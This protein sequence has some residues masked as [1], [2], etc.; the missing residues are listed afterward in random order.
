[1]SVLVLVHVVEHNCFKIF[2][3]LGVQLLLRAF[4]VC[5]LGK[6]NSLHL[7]EHSKKTGFVKFMPAGYNQ[8]TH[9]VYRRKLGKRGTKQT[10]GQRQPGESR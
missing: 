3:T 1:M 7:A 2:C 4:P 6:D 8:N 5:G 10:E 9:F